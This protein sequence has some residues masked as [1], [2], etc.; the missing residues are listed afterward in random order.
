ME[1]ESNISLGGALI[2]LAL[3]AQNIFVRKKIHFEA[4]LLHSQSFYKN[5]IVQKGIKKTL[6]KPME[7]TAPIPKTPRDYSGFVASDPKIA[8]GRFK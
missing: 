2:L 4:I 6:N 5:S 8:T 1:K 3:H 7:T